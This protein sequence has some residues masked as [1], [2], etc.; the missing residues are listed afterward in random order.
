MFMRRCSC[1][2]FG[3]VKVVV[4][5]HAQWMGKQCPWLCG[6]EHHAKNKVVSVL[7][8]ARTHDI[9]AAG[10]GVGS[11]RRASLWSAAQVRVLSRIRSRSFLA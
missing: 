5:K 1:V 4:D 11:T 7:C 6:F 10:G 8:C 3:T 9:G 2:L